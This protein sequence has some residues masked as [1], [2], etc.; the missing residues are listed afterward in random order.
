MWGET[1]RLV[2]RK[3]ILWGH[4]R[5]ES[6]GQR[7]VLKWRKWLEYEEN[8]TRKDWKICTSP[9]TVRIIQIRRVVWAWHVARRQRSEMHTQ[10]QHE[11]MKESY[12]SLYKSIDG[13]E[14]LGALWWIFGR[15]WPDERLSAAQGHIHALPYHQIQPIVTKAR[16]KRLHPPPRYFTA[17]I[18]RIGGWMWTRVR[19]KAVGKKYPQPCR[20]SHPGSP[21]NSIVTILTELSGIRKTPFS[22]SRP[23]PRTSI[24]PVSGRTGVT[25]KYSVR[26]TQ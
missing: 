26:T 25:F 11:N 12:C 1:W 6:W 15:P 8:C 13:V 5:K 7:F 2:L 16:G 21:F 19:L 22:P 9:K 23:S 20:I 17:G 18:H 3:S 24:N 4:L 14:L 10:F